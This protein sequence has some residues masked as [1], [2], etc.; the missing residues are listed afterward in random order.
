[1]DSVQE[2]SKGVASTLLMRFMWP[3]GGRSVFVIG[4]FNRW[5]QLVPMSPVEGCPKIF[6]VIYPITPGYHQV[7]LLVC[8][9]WAKLSILIRDSIAFYFL[10]QISK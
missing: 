10:L 1:M 5:S 6:Q 4:S 3:H 9:G 2:A 8:F 7:F